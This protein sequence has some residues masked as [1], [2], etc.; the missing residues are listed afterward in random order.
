MPSWELDSDSDISLRRQAREVVSV[1]SQSLALLSVETRE[2][3]PPP[4]LDAPASPDPRFAERSDTCDAHDAGSLDRARSPHAQDAMTPLVLPPPQTFSSQPPRAAVRRPSKA[5]S[6]AAVAATNVAASAPAAAAS[7]PRPAVSTTRVGRPTKQPPP[8]CRSPSPPQGA[9]AL[10]AGGGGGAASSTARMRTAQSKVM[11]PPPAGAGF[12]ADPRV[13]KDEALAVERAARYVREVR[14][15]SSAAAGRGGGREPAGVAALRRWTTT[16]VLGR[17][18]NAW[19]RLELQRAESELVG[20]VREL[21]AR[22]AV[23]GSERAAAAAGSGSGGGGWGAGN[24]ETHL[25]SVGGS[26]GGGGGG[27]TPR[28]TVPLRLL[29]LPRALESPAVQGPILECKV[30]SPPNPAGEDGG[31]PASTS[32]TSRGASAAPPYPTRSLK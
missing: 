5:P 10:L 31:R 9:A 27:M 13:A 7:S 15:S 23:L 16:H 28:S 8:S 26:A 24:I 3:P 6:L 21:Q 32:A 18:F 11:S 30:F 29:P 22:L 4:L 1:E 19:R 20:A 2:L 12:S 17:Y 25:L 14:V